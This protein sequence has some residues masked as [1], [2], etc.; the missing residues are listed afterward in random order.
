M[1]CEWHSDAYYH[2]NTFLFYHGSNGYI[3][4]HQ[5]VSVEFSSQFH[6]CCPNRWWFLWV[7]QAL[8]QLLADHHC[9]FWWAAGI[10]IEK[11]WPPFLPILHHNVAKDIPLHTQRI[12]YLAYGI[13]LGTKL[14]IQSME[15]S[16][17]RLFPVWLLPCLIQFQW[18]LH[19][20]CS[21]QTVLILCSTVPWLI[22]H[23]F[24]L[25]CVP[26]LFHQGW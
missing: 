9:V 23:S 26:L 5:T 16:N 11:N 20:L 21:L 24:I 8:W 1:L 17:C 13:W 3:G 19:T 25:V 14:F 10:L 12:Q 6:G 22:P 18:T 7:S 2:M 4:Y 15:P